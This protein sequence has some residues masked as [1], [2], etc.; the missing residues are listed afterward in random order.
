V[1]GELAG[2]A[3]MSPIMFCNDH[4]TAGLLVQPVNDARPLHTADTGET[5]AAMSDER[6]DQCARPVA[7]RRVHDQPCRFV[8]DDEVVI[9]IKNVERDVFA[10]RDGRLGWRHR[11]VESIALFDPVVR[12]F[13]RPA[14]VPS[15]PLLDQG[16]QPGAT[17]LGQVSGKVAVQPFACVLFIDGKGINLGAIARHWDPWRD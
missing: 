5:V 6:I 14:I 16:F 8:D 12:L 3:V 7:R 15:V 11:D 9:L 10:A 1:I 2:E 13:Y 4:D 17:E